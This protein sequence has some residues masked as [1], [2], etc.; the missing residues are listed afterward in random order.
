MK[1]S[2]IHVSFAA[3]GFA[4]AASAGCVAEPAPDSDESTGAVGLDCGPQPMVPVCNR[5]VCTADAGWVAWPKDAGTACHTDVGSGVCDGGDPGGPGQQE[6]DRLGECIVPAGAL[7]PEYRVIGVLYSPPG[8]N[9]GNSSSVTYGSNIS[10]SAQTETTKTFKQNYSLQATLEIPL[11]SDLLKS[12]S[13]SANAGFTL[14]S[15]NRNSLALKNSSV[16]SETHNGPDRDG[17]HH[18]ED[19]LMLWLNPRV[20]FAAHGNST[21]WTLE[22]NPDD[23]NGTDIERLTVKIGWLKGTMPMPPGVAA[24]L[25]HHR[26]TP[27]DY[28]DLLAH[29]EFANG[30]TAVD[31]NQFVRT[32][33]SFPYEP[34][35]SQNGA[36]NTYTLTLANDVTAVTSTTKSRDSTV[37]A[38]VAGTIPL[39]QYLNLRLNSST[40]FTWT[41]QTTNTATAIS[42][43][44]AQ[45]TVKGPSFG[46]T[47]PVNIT[48]WFDTMYKTFLFE[49]VRTAQPS[50]RGIVRSTLNE[51]LAHVFVYLRKGGRLYQTVTNARGEYR[52]YDHTPGAANVWVTGATPRDVVLTK[53]TVS[54]DLVQPRKP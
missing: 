35:T 52:L 7:D 31:P 9:G 32:G 24:E 51:P 26:I 37:G 12:F 36:P 29:D 28:P 1:R 34:P 43:E 3:L 39:S 50:L 17:I 4:A 14:T 5:N 18:D 53:E 16:A 10:Y 8:R 40:Q 30:N 13:A 25:A 19:E 45:A 48:V 11:I 20:Y 54:L 23:H 41:Y 44:S 49:F 47:G 42:G 38:Q 21:D 2:T 22:V 33:L 15:T 27:A 46:Y 6:P